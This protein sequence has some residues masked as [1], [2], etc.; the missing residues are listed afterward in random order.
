LSK[1]KRRSGSM[2]GGVGAPGTSGAT[3]FS[4]AVLTGAGVRRSR[5]TGSVLREFGEGGAPGRSS[6]GAIATGG[7][8]SVGRAGVVSGRLASREGG[9]GRGPHH[10]S[11]GGRVISND[12]PVLASGGKVA[13]VTGASGATS[14]RAGPAGIPVPERTRLAGDPS[15]CAGSGG[16]GS[17]G[18]TLRSSPA[19]CG[20]V[21]ED[22]GGSV[23]G[24]TSGRGATPVGRAGFVT[25]VPGA[26]GVRS[27]GANCP[28][29]ECPGCECP[30][31]NCPGGSMH[32]AGAL[33][34]VGLPPP[35]VEL[36]C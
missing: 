27:E 22:V 30:G 28:G 25:P 4:G 10:G 18:G 11:L 8:G 1:S 26:P 31:V 5:S 21:T 36:F 29:F 12:A 3:G 13:G 9:F 14:T 24:G 17:D 34:P 20:S 7:A 15:C 33:A 32:C 6:S 19:D 16:S 2:A 35:A 23:V